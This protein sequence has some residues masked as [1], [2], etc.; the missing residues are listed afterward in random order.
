MEINVESTVRRPR[1]RGVRTK[2]GGRTA[3]HAQDEAGGERGRDNDFANDASTP[4]LD[5]PAAA[6]A[7]DPEATECDALF[8]APSAMC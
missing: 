3:F 5:P 1:V 7:A 4:P 8:A 2:L 6:E